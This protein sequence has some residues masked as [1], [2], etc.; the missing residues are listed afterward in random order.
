MWEWEEWVSFEAEGREFPSLQELY[1][2]GCPK[3]KGNLPKQ[4][5]SVVKVEISESKELVNTLM[6]EESLQKRLLD[7]HDKI[8]F[9][10]DETGSAESSLSK[11]QY[12]AAAECSLHMTQGVVQSSFDMTLGDTQSSLAIT[13]GAAVAECSLLVAQSVA[14]AE[15]SFSIIQKVNNGSPEVLKNKLQSLLLVVDDAEEKQYRSKVVK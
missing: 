8:L 2:R 6:A 1:I 13:Q 9:V 3:L 4:L 10:S 15:C 12:A 11:S 14:A 5:P 7:Y